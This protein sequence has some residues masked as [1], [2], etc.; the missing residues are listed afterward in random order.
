MWKIALCITV[1]EVSVIPNVI[2][3]V[4]FLNIFNSKLSRFMFKLLE[5]DIS[6]MVV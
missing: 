4:Q 6:N 2:I 3:E 1:S 5:K